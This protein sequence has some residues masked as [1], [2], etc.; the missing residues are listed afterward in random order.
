MCR[1]FSQA[2]GSDGAPQASLQRPNLRFM[3]GDTRIFSRNYLYFRLIYGLENARI[4]DIREF[5]KAAAEAD[6]QRKAERMRKSK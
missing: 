5:E 6:R 3:P 4:V 1:P 2:L